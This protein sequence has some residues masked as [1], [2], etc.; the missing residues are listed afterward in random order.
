VAIAENGGLTCFECDCEKIRALINIGLAVI[1]LTVA[2]R[3]RNKESMRLA[4]E[5]ISKAQRSSKMGSI[6]IL[7]EAKAYLLLV[8]DGE[9][10][11]QEKLDRLND[12]LVE[13]MRRDFKQ[14]ETPVK[15][16]DSGG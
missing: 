7:E 16:I 4:V 3:A 10:D 1:A 13:S 2:I 15:I 6:E 8:E 12:E 5:A 14:P 11:M 9:E